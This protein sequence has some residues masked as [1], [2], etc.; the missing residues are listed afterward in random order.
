MTCDRLHAVAAVRVETLVDVVGHHPHRKAGAR[1]GSDLVPGRELHGGH[2]QQQQGSEGNGAGHSRR[3]RRPVHA[4]A[5]R[6][7]R[8]QQRGERADHPLRNGNRDVVLGVVDEQEHQQRQHAN[9]GPCRHGPFAPPAGRGG[10][11]PRRRDHQH[12]A[13]DMTHQYRDR[14]QGSRPRHG[15]RCD[16]Y[17]AQQRQQTAV[18][19]H[20]A[21]GQPQRHHHRRQIRGQDPGEHQRLRPAGVHRQPRDVLERQELQHQRRPEN[22]AAGAPGDSCCRVSCGRERTRRRREPQ[23]DPLRRYEGRGDHVR[24]PAARPREVDRSER[25]LD[26]RVDR[27]RQQERNRGMWSTLGGACGEERSQHERKRPQEEHRAGDRQ[28]QVRRQ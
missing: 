7:K 23:Q 27:Q 16:Q 8:D 5:Q 11:G 2:C 15:H 1:A 24:L 20:P 13:H 3:H 26:G 4:G 14:R 19:R 22:Q 6:R 21:P 18:R 17:A 12:R 10:C 9:G 28:R 25:A